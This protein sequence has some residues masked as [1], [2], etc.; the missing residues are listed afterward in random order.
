ML[1]NSIFVLSLIVANYF[2]FNPG[3]KRTLFRVKK[4]L[5]KHLSDP[6]DFF[7]RQYF[8]VKGNFPCDFALEFYQA[9]VNPFQRQFWG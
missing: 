2:Q 5:I 6:K 4:K 3:Q 1:G 9:E 8:E 7:S